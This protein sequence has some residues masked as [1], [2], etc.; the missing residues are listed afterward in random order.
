MRLNGKMRLMAAATLI[1]VLGGG[2]FAAR[3]W[4]DPVEDSKI[5][6]CNISSDGCDAG[7]STC[8]YACHSGKCRCDQSS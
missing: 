8:A 7:L 2:M 3:S 4:A 6:R 1:G 5:Y